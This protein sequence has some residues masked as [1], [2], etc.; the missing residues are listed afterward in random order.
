MK[1]YLVVF[2]ISLMPSLVNA[3]LVE[4]SLDISKEKMSITG[5]S[6]DKITVNH[7]IPGPTLYFTEEDDALIHVTNHMD[8]T[9]S[10]HWHGLLVP[11]DMDGVPGMGGFSGIKSHQTFDYRFHIRQSGTYW[12]HSH[13]AGQEQDG[14]YGA[15]VIS[16]QVD[17]VKVDQD[18]VLL[19]SDYSQESSREI[20][21]N[22][23]MSSDYYQYARSTISDFFKTVR[24]KGFKETL[25]DSQMWGQMRMLRTDLSDVS[26]YTFL[27]N[28]APPNHPWKGILKENETARLRI[29]NGSAMSIYD[30][31]IP[32]LSLKVVAADGQAVEPIDVDEFRFA[33]GETYDVLVT[34]TQNKAFTFVAEPI[35][36]TGFALATLTP[37]IELQGEIPQQ[38]PRALLTMA[39]MGM[40]DMSMGDMSGMDMSSHSPMAHTHHIVVGQSQPSSGDSG[41]A[42]SGADS[43]LKILT[44][45]NLR[46]LG[47]QPE[48]KKPS[49]EIE[50][51][52]DGN[53]QRYIWLINGQKFNEA[54]PIHLA[55][56]ERIRLTFINQS[57]M[58]HPMHLHGMFMQ[59]ENG[60]SPD[61]LP[62]K[63]TII[64]PPGGRYSALLT[65]SETGEWVFH[66]HLLYHM[67]TGMMTS[68]DVS[69]SAPVE[70]EAR[71]HEHHSGMHHAH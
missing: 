64:I 42:L 13:S 26:Q 27:I 44:Y 35:D 29:I 14:L 67:Q 31:R 39:D 38:R 57:M 61:K 48:Q 54:K 70:T 12:Y 36:R 15:I 49:R 55:H 63:H 9:T 37:S 34:P 8:E 62:N 60:Q 56:G 28:G 59:L 33:P 47:V 25:E 23:K 19:I 71:A 5:T 22:L 69:P 24:Q 66:C 18:F 7:S 17:P 50:L 6:I 30:V 68:I 52:L 65:A 43:K 41:W 51:V 4:Y 58:A 11:N 10:I 16:P 46:Y 2:M 40:G 20:L 3:K 21:S 45:K 53:M 32:G 1:K